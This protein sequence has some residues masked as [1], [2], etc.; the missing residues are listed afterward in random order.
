[1]SLL[2]VPIVAL[3]FCVETTLGFGATV[4]AVS[5][6]ALLVDVRLL[7]P[8]FVPLNIAL[9]LLIVARDRAHV[10]RRLL[11][12]R[13]LPAMAVGLPVGMFAFSALDAELLRRVLGVVVVALALRELFGLGR[14]A[15]GTVRAA[16]LVAAGAVHGALG[17]GGPLVVWSLGDRTDSPRAMRATLSAL[18]LALNL[19]L[20]AGYAWQGRLDAQSARGS[21]LCAG[22]LV[23]GALAGELL[24]RRVDAA[25]FGRAVWVAL[26]V[27]GTLL[28]VR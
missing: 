10:D 5:L 17:S 27:I 16:A 1:M 22:G 20:V 26:A 12:R 3:A 8:A 11:L 21:A 24:H 18:W 2:L 15:S 7:L 4:V 13:V 25:R 23:V 19:V 9:S 28:L 6:G 14:R